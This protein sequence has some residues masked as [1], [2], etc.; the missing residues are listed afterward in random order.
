MYLGMLILFLTYAS[1]FL[2]LNFILHPI[3]CCDSVVQNKQLTKCHI[4][5]RIVAVRTC[6]HKQHLHSLLLAGPVFSLI[7]NILL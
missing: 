3:N 4:P 2:G 1:E 6:K 7:L 5:K